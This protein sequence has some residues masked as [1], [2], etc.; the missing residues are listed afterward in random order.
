MSSFKENGEMSDDDSTSESDSSD[1]E[2]DS[3]AVGLDRD[4]R[5]TK[6]CAVDQPNQQL[7]HQRKPHQHPH[8]HNHHH[9]HH[10]PV[11]VVW[12]PP[13]NA[14]TPS[15]SYSNPIRFDTNPKLGPKMQLLCKTGYLLA[16]YPDGKVR[17]T[18]DSNDLHTYLELFSAGHPGH[19][20]IKGLLTNL[21]VAMNR[22]GRLYGESLIK[23][24]GDPMMENNVFIESFQGSYTTY[25]SRKFAHLGWY[26]AIKKNGK[27][28]KGP[29]TRY[30]QKAVKFLPLRRK[31]E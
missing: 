7:H 14:T 19:V 9:R 8:H 2:V 23:S 10:A 5:Q 12:P 24:H 25:L 20:R 11:K 15:T 1:D 6:W 29:K 26:V 17:G 4:K 22:R 27:I 18:A 21:Y 28:K 31:F 3:I 16:V 13:S 30:G